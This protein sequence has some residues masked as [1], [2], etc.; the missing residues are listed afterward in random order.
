MARNFARHKGMKDELADDF[1]HNELVVQLCT[2]L[3]MMMEDLSPLALNA[4]P[5]G[6]RARVIEIALG[7]RTMAAIADAA[8]ALVDL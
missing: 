6:L 3:G 7:I 1:E 5:E 4:S 2:R 8:K